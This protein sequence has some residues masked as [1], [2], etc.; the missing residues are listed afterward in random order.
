[1]FQNTALHQAAQAGHSGTTILLLSMGAEFIKN[2]DKLHFLDMAIENRHKDVTMAVV[3]HD[4]SV[5]ALTTR[6]NL[7]T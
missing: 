6:N 1:M 3:S 7:F 4:R 5:I 2:K